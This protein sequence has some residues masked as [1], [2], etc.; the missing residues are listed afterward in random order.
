MAFKILIIDDDS[1]VRM[2]L[3]ALLSEEGYEVIMV[4]SGEDALGLLPDS[5]LD[6]IF[7]DVMLPG[8]DGLEVLKQV[9]HRYPDIAVVMIS[10]HADLSMAVQATKLGAYDFIEKPLNAE[11]VLL[12]AKNVFQKIMIENEI[13]HLK[14]L[15]DID[16]TLIGNTPAMM[17]LY[18]NL[19][20]VAPSDSKI[21]I[22]GENGTGKELVAREIHKL[23][24]RSDKPFIKLNCAAL[25][26]ELIESELF[27]YERGAFTGADRKK[28]G[29]IEEANLGTLFLDEVGDMSLDTQA[30][31][32]R[33]LQEN[34]FKRVGGN[35]PIP[36]DVRIVS[37]TNKDLVNL[38][39]K[40]EFREDLYFRLNVIPLRVPA[41]RERIDDIPLLADHFLKAY[42]IR[43]NKKA[44]RISEP[45]KTILRQYDWPGNVRELKNLIERL[46]IMIDDDEIK[47]FDIIKF[48]SNREQMVVR[49][50]VESGSRSTLKQQLERF[51]RDVLQEEFIRSQ[52]NI[53]KMA[54]KLKTDRAN[55]SRKLKRYGI[56]NGGL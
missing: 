28:I 26:R 29:L 4:A 34:E 22:L 9:K 25:P 39:Q 53:T 31:L 49:H 45:A 1:Y 56:S 36:F 18:E 48:L 16:Y 8:I 13:T 5:P 27:G 21:V 2:S 32:L 17:D 23:S 51:E 54:L 47:D 19:R 43:N 41:L 55:L 46:V 44:K 20:K 30:K 10:G 6:M 50:P 14:K 12:A 11:K 24:H 42:A 33:V 7:L 15:V 3:A 40:N 38:I 35:Q 37:A 52:G